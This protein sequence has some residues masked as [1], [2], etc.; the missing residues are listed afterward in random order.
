M[1]MKDVMQGVTQ[2]AED[3]ASFP[4]KLGKRLRGR[5]D[6]GDVP[7]LFELLKR[8]RGD[9]WRKVLEDFESGIIEGGWAV[10]SAGIKAG[11]SLSPGE[12]QK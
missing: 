3:V 2:G 12:Q 5:L 11:V 7:E 9:G 10:P 8:I 6:A 4:F 1:G